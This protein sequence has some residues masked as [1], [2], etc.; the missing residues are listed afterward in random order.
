MHIG[1]DEAISIYA[2]ACRAW[3]GNKAYAVALETAEQL[4]KRGDQTGATVWRRV[5]QE[6]S[7]MP[8]PICRSTFR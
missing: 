6:A 4:R 5:A 7:R 1:L 8:E 3:Y 2:Q